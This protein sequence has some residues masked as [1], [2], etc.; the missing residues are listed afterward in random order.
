M[1]RVA[2][3]PG[4]WKCPSRLCQAHNFASKTKCFKCGNSK[5]G[6]RGAGGREGDWVCKACQGNN[7]SNKV[8]CFKC[9][10]Q[11]PEDATP[12][13]GASAGDAPKRERRKKKKRQQFE[14]TGVYFE[15]LP[16]GQLLFDVQ[17]IVRELC[18]PFGTMRKV[19]AY[20][21]K[22]DENLSQGDA[23]AVFS[24]AEQAD[25]ACAQLQNHPIYKVSRATFQPK[26][27]KAPPANG[28]ESVAAANSSTNAAGSK[29]TPSGTTAGV[30]G[31]PAVPLA[32]KPSST[33]DTVFIADVFDPLAETS[34][35]EAD[36]KRKCAAFGDIA[37]WFV[38]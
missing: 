37:K 2:A 26:A 38:L 27:K 13:P 25:T 34:K 24:S 28:E 5:P 16:R 19:N 11:K 10:L 12:A 30:S 6:S 23:L 31:A 29:A 1:Q 18:L 32:V 20:R 17:Q 22:E 4:D 14:N 8:A 9:G 7:F 33:S 3:R 36:L 35:D 21:S 15:N